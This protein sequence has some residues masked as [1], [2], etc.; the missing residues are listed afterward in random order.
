MDPKTLKRTDMGLTGAVIILC[1]VISSFQSSRNLSQ[2]IDQ[3]KSA[4]HEEKAE[5]EKYFVKKEELGEVSL[6]LDKMSK[7]LFVIQ[8]QIKNL[9]FVSSDSETI[10]GC[11]YNR[12]FSNAL[13][14]L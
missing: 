10:I 12:S 14:H 13:G 1:Q 4:F 2:E 3:L 7:R 9:N 5:H 6:K 11:R 8:K